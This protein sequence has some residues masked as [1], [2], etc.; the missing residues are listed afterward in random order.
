MNDILYFIIIIGLTIFIIFYGGHNHQNLVEYNSKYFCNLSS[1]I[2]YEKK[3]NEFINDDNMIFN[4]DNFLNL[5]KY[6]DTSDIIIPNFVGCYYIQIKSF[7][8]FN[9]NKIV[10][11]KDMI[12]NM[13]IIFNHHKHNDIELIINDSTNNLYKNNNLIND[14]TF[15]TGYFYDLEKKISITGVYHLYNN[16]NQNIIITCFILKKPFWFE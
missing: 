3:L 12:Y 1:I 15:I 7:D 8:I 10:K 14:K 2:I 16:S 11:K 6:L 5:N 9:I 13:M 4:Q